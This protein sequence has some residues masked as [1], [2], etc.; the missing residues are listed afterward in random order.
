MLGIFF[1]HLPY[2]KVTRDMTMPMTQLI[3][4]EPKRAM[5]L[6]WG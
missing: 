3:I 5:G 6:P 2:L 4:R 1:L